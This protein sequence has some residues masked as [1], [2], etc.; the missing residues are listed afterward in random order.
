MPHGCKRLET[1]AL[2]MVLSRD[3]ARKNRAGLPAESK[4]VTMITKLCLPAPDSRR[5][6]DENSETNLESPV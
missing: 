2:R 1:I 4:L 5:K 6:S 3:F